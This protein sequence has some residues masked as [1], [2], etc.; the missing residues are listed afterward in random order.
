MSRKKRRP[1]HHSAARGAKVQIRLN[2]GGEL[3]VTKFRRTS[4]N[5]RFLITDAGT[6]RW[7]KVEIFRVVKGVPS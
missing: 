4:D 1:K 5:H 2:N 7:N 3:F 6:F